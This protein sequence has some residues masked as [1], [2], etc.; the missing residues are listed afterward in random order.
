MR[1]DPPATP[2]QGADWHPADVLAALKKRGKSLAGISIAHGYH[3]TAAG[4]ALKRPWPAM[5]RAIAAE[6]GIPPEEIWPSRYPPV[7]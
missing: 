7:D 5:E 2:R 4:K 1:E 3:P 6:L